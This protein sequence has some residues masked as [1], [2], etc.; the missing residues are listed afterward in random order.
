VVICNRMKLTVALSIAAMVMIQ[1]ALPKIARAI[2][3]TWIA[4]SAVNNN[5]NSTG[6]WRGNNP[7]QDDDDLYFDG[8]GT[9]VSNN[10][11]PDLSINT[12]S[13]RGAVSYTL[14][15]NNLTLDSGLYVQ[16]NSTDAI[17]TINLDG[18]DG[19]YIQFDGSGNLVFE[20]AGKTYNFDADTGLWAKDQTSSPVINVGNNSLAF[21]GGAYIGSDKSS[22][23]VT[24]EISGGSGGSVSFGDTI[25]LEKYG[26]LNLTGAQATTVAGVITGAG[27]LIQS[28]SGVTTLSETNDFTGDTIVSGG[29]LDVTGMISASNITISGGTLCGPGGSV[30]SVILNSGVLQAHDAETSTGVLTIANLTTKGGSLSFNVSKGSNIDSLNV[31]GKAILGAGTLLKIN[32]LSAAI[33]FAGEN[34]PIIKSTGLINNCV[35]FTNGVG[36]TITFGNIVLTPYVGG[37]KPSGGVKNDADIQ[38]NP[39]YIYLYSSGGVGT[40]SAAK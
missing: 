3:D 10:N 14:T 24:L 25:N 13:F 12:I 18:I 16:T 8:S 23:N 31:D 2:S 4:K 15:G 27:R 40:P 11:M 26:T 38:S 22:D 39:N 21:S 34:I 7:P 20:S 28:G 32:L 35:G 9:L 19:Q 30:Q 33:P 1:G 36:S 6:A 29:I 5:W 17:E 37:S